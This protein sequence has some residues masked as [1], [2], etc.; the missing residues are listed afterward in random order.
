MGC[1][2]ACPNNT[3]PLSNCNEPVL[4][5]IWSKCEIAILTYRIRIFNYLS[6]S[7]IACVSIHT[8]SCQAESRFM[9][10]LKAHDSSGRGAFL[11]SVMERA[12][13]QCL[14]TKTL[15]PKPYT[16]NPINP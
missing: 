4:W 16:L 15:N 12:Q 1:G 14:A 13:K 8:Q 11:V 6:F 5:A 2:V 7:G 10:D 9:C 3:K